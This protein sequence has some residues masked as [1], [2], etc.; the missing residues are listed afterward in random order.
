MRRMETRV[1]PVRR[2]RSGRRSQRRQPAVGQRDTEALVFGER[3]GVRRRRRCDAA[4][5]MDERLADEAIARVEIARGSMPAGNGAAPH[6]LQRSCQKLM[7]EQAGPF[8]AGGK[9]DTALSRIA[10]I[11]NNRFAQCHVGGE[12]RFNPDLQDWFELTR[13][14]RLAE[15]VVRA[16]LAR[17][18]SRGAH[19]RDDFPA[20]TIAGSREI[21][22]WRS[23]DGAMARRWIGRSGRN[24]IAR[25]HD[26]TDSTRVTHLRVW[27]GS[28]RRGLLRRL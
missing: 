1:G 12:Q 26:G 9:L 2:G 3:A 7:W 22:C 21:R 23:K 28:R 16:A 18:E 24:P 27:R 20:Q 14:A 13:D 17:E 11:T 8:R 6:A 10:E 19:Q 15:A 25:E 5:R 4:R